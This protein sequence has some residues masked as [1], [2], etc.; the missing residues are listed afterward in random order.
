M[1]SHVLGIGFVYMEKEYKLAIGIV[2]MDNLF[3]FAKIIH[4]A[5]VSF[6]VESISSSLSTFELLQIYMK[7]AT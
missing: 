7:D 3:V 1:I 5:V 6:Y 4:Q 2:W